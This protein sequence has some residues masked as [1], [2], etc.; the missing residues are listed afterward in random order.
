MR[1]H[2]CAWAL[3]WAPG[4]DFAQYSIQPVP[5]GAGPFYGMAI[6]G[7]PIVTVFRV[8]CR[9]LP[10]L[11]L[12]LLGLARPAAATAGGY[13]GGG[14]GYP[15]EPGVWRLHG[16]SPALPPDD[17]E[18]L[19]RVVANARFVGLGESIHTSG[20]YYQMK[21][22]VVR[23]LVQNMGF[24]AFGIEGPW[25]RTDL[26]NAYVQT[27][28]GTPQEA[29]A[30]LFQVFQSAEV[31]AMLRWMCEWNRDHP[32]DRIQLYGFD[33]Q[34]QTAQDIQALRAFLQ[35][36]GIGVDDPRFAGFR[37]CDGMDET[38]IPGRPYPEASYQPCKEALAAAASLFD[39]Q[40]GE[41]VERTSEEDLAWARIAL[42]GQQAWQ[43]QIFHLG[44]SFRL[45]NS[46]RDRGMAYVAQAIHSLRFPHARTALWAHNSHIAKGADI[47]TSLRFHS[48]G[49]LLAAQLGPQYTNFALASYRTSIDWFIEGV[50][51]GCDSFL[52]FVPRPVE[53]YL[54]SRGQGSAL[55][56]DLRAQGGQA[57]FLEEGV[58]YGLGDLRNLILG[59]HF[60]AI[61][62]LPD[63]PGMTPHAWVPC[64]LHD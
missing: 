48:M 64:P 51:G 2:S 39:S 33:V 18:P 23:F 43:E 22:R 6:Q 49:T 11:P 37:A 17:L 1:K 14:P 53:T 31:G 5:A 34:F 52:P 54:M 10:V 61:L 56:A 32:E 19:R 58:R 26:V 29:Q 9:T 46:A 63:S 62:F 30:P 4:A 25:R 8:L 44:R 45:S 7:G 38:F 40:E 28:E 42:V 21:D 24:R 13:P 59:D 55:L 3:A 57:P 15:L 12:L 27:C 60:D 47:S 41:I 50:P 35:R 20:G 36:L 16:F